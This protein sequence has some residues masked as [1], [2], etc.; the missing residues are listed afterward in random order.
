[1]A[2]RNL[3][4]AERQHFSYA[5]VGR[6]SIMRVLFTNQPSMGHWH[7]LVP[8]AQALQARGH[9]IA[10]ASTPNFSPIIEAKGFRCFRAGVDES[11]EEVQER[12]KQQ[13]TRTPGEA[14]NF[15]QSS[16]FAGTRAEHSLPDLLQI[17]RGW[18]PNVVVREN[19]EYAGCIAAEHGGFPHAVVQITAPRASLL[20]IVD[21][22]LRRLRA[23]VGL[24]PCEPAE[25]LHRYLYLSPRPQSLWNPAVQVPPT[26]FTYRFAGFSQSG[27]EELPDWVAQ[28]DG[29][30]PTIYATLGT[31][32][33]HRTEIFLAILEAFREEPIN[34]ILTV[35]RNRDPLEF[36][37]QPAHV[38][39]VYIE[40]YIPQNLL[41][42]HCSM[43]ITH[44]GSGTMMDALSLGLPMVIIPIGADQPEN[45]E[46]CAE[47]GVARVIEPSGRTPEAIREATRAV[48]QDPKYRQAAQRIQKEIEE[49]SGLEYPVA[50]L[51]RLAA[52]RTPLRS[53]N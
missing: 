26:M 18:Q 49:M 12:R 7:P 19:T 40:R 3:R 52:E 41:L 29:G 53:D 34:L 38:Y 30:T 14:A 33:N 44:G 23:S 9:E 17:M 42:P 6:G 13:A 24:P 36:G 8:L 5:R 35:G 43:I 4:K 11:D 22:P 48:L 15:M 25:M 32:Q 10:F 20:Q 2:D 31:M 45:A 37:E 1:M 51:E 27:E 16:V 21:A 50:L 47:A 46:R 28:L 39:H